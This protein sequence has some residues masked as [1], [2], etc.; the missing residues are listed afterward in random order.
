[1]II[2]GGFLC[3]RRARQLDALRVWTPYCLTLGEKRK[4]FFFG[5]GL[6]GKCGFLHVTNFVCE[7]SFSAVCVG[8]HQPVSPSCSARKDG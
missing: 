3:R 1:M 4:P 7:I 5:G 6:T 2:T 8:V